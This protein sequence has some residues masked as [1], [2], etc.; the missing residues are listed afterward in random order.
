[1][2]RK[3][4]LFNPENDLALAN[5][6]ENF[7]APLSARTMAFDLSLLPVWYAADNAVILVPDN[8]RKTLPPELIQLSGSG[9]QILQYQQYKNSS[10]PEDVFCPW[11]WSPSINKFWSRLTGTVFSPVSSGLKKYRTL[12]HRAFT[13][14]VLKELQKK[15]LL[16]E[17]IILP[18]QF[19]ALN[20]VKEFVDHHFPVLLKAPWSGSGKGLLWNYKGWNEKTEQ[21]CTRFIEKQGSVIGEHIWQKKEDFAMQFYSDGKK[22]VSFTG[23]SW[24]ATN[25]YGV[26]FQNRLT[27]DPLIEEKLHFYSSSGYIEKLRSALAEI[28]SLQIAPYYQ[29]YFGVDMMVCQKNNQYFIYPCVEINLRMNMGMTSRLFYNNYVSSSSEGILSVDYH[30]DPE[31]L[32]RD[33]QKRKKENPLQIIDGKI[34]QGYLSLCP[35]EA[36]TRYRAWIHVEK[37]S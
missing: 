15:S 3:I 17:K 27:S 21:W 16:D 30:G 22:D 31:K 7:E 1:M 12:S 24:F 29:G 26:Y 33:H 25:P 36:N 14:E 20:E 5:G 4:Y 23:Y 8:F 19:F 34:T 9:K 2:S 28:F 13:I 35:I 6:N 32:G 10:Q 37:R 11:G 18:E